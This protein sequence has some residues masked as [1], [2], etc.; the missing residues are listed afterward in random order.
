MQTAYLSFDLIPSFFEFHF[1]GEST[2]FYEERSAA[3]QKRFENRERSPLDYILVQLGDKTIW[4]FLIFAD[5]DAAFGVQTP[6]HMADIEFHENDWMP[7]MALIKRRLQ[8]LNAKQTSL[9]FTSA[10]MTRQ[11]PVALGAIGFKKKSD[12][13][14][15][16]G[17]LQNLPTEAGTPFT[18]KAVDGKDVTVEFAAEIL[19]N[20]SKGDPNWDSG[21]SA[22]DLIK[23]DLDTDELY[24]NLDAIQIGYF[25]QRP[26]AFVFAQVEK[27]SGWSRLT[28]MGLSPE[29]RGQ[30]FAK[31]VHRHGFEMMRKQGGKEY[32]GSTTDTN[33]SMLG[34]F[35]SQGCNEY[36]RIQEWIVHNK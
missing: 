35:Q 36:R 33:E 29:L 28:Y 13:V 1:P 11:L 22:L 21:A 3:L 10:K 15:F 20:C 19:D 14:E 6:K 16:K 8:E 26:V 9:R 31:W 18:W 23:N 12:R 2:Q 30:G 27:G 32:H 34:T 24:N 25:N 4:S 7:S 17:P 5:G